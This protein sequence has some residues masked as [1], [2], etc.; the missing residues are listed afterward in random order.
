[1]A[2]Y[3]DKQ[4]EWVVAG[5]RDYNDLDWTVAQGRRAVVF[6]TAHPAAESK[7]E[8]VVFAGSNTQ[9]T[10]LV[11]ASLAGQGPKIVA[12][13]FPSLRR[14]AQASGAHAGMTFMNKKAFLRL[15]AEHP[16]LVEEAQK[17]G[18]NNS[19]A[20]IK[21]VERDPKLKPGHKG[22]PCLFRPK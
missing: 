14:D 5:L 3:E 10:N 20:G 21:C 2:M 12:M 8:N 18:A 22:T 17:R 4:Y 9:I 11:E 19:A 7:Y 6:A 1:M 16:E 15:Q 13:L